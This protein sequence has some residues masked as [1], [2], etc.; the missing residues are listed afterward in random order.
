V[1]E[2]HTPFS[3]TQGFV[4]RKEPLVPEEAIVSLAYPGDRQRV[5]AGRFVKYG[6][7]EG[8]EGRRSSKCMMERTASCLITGPQVRRY[9]IAGAESSLSLATRSL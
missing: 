7:G 4:L 6:D 3:G 5:A 2:L 1:L 9:S 8:L